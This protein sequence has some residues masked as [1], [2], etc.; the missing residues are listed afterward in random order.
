[1]I[2]PM[3]ARLGSYIHERSVFTITSESIRRNPS[4]YNSQSFC[5]DAQC[6][7]LAQ[8]LLTFILFGNLSRRA[9]KSSI[10]P[11][12]LS[13]RV[14]PSMGTNG[15]LFELSNTVTFASG[16]CLKTLK[17]QA[18][19]RSGVLKCTMQ[20]LFSI[21]KNEGGPHRKHPPSV[22]KRGCRLRT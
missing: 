9:S 17:T 18:L 21:N 19:V 12:V 14:T 8:S 20:T 11:R 15:F 6:F 3:N 22:V 2:S 5:M 4:G 1:M 16:I 13:R 10:C 7:A